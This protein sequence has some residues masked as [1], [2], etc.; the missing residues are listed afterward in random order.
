LLSNGFNDED[1]FPDIECRA[2]FNDSLLIQGN[3]EQVKYLGTIN[4]ELFSRQSGLN[5]AIGLL[6]KLENDV[7]DVLNYIEKE[8][9]I[10][11][12][13]V[14]KEY[15]KHSLQLERISYHFEDR[16]VNRG[17]PDIGKPGLFL[18][19]TYFK[20][21]EKIHLLPELRADYWSCQMR[22]ARNLERIQLLLTDKAEKE[23]QKAND[24]LVQII[25]V[26]AVLEILFNILTIVTGLV[27]DE[28]LI[29]VVIGSIGVLIGLLWLYIRINTLKKE[30]R[31]IRL[32]KRNNLK[33]RMFRLS[34]FI[35]SLD[36]IIHS[37]VGDKSYFV[38]AKDISKAQLEETKQELEK[39]ETLL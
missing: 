24:R 7:H 34:A 18:E 1:L 16:F 22:I 8:S 29:F 26:F 33:Q 30:K 15:E 4:E 3:N 13:Y 31:A 14:Q 38:E 23:E 17:F 6:D 27:D 19:S 25:G 28:L 5:T 35:T 11:W 10:S 39:I 21:L 32:Q 2:T 9:P 36:S 37:F 20:N 12:L